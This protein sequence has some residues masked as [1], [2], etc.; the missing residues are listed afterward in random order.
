MRAEVAGGPNTVANDDALDLGATVL[1]ISS[2]AYWQ[3]ALTVVLVLVVLRQIRRA[4]A[5][6]LTRPIGW[7]SARLGQHRPEL[8]DHPL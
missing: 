5:C 2:K 6:R 3:Q 8:L 1:P 4:R 7:R